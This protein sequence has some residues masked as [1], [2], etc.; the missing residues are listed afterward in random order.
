MSIFTKD[1]VTVYK[2]EHVIITC[3]RKPINIGKRYGCDRY[4]IPLTQ[5]HGKWQPCRTIKAEIIQLQLERSLYDLSYKEEAIKWIHTV[6]GYPVKSIKAGNHVGWTMLTE[7]NITRYYPETNE[8]PKRNLNQSRKNIRSTKPKRTPLEVSKTATL[9][10]H[11]ARD[12]YIS[13]YKLRNT[14]FSDQTYQLPTR[15]Q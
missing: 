15:S 5:D 6:C 12:V 14:V 1:G 13:V 9:R 3:Q 4:R 8:T 10:G 11:K 2:E 7:R